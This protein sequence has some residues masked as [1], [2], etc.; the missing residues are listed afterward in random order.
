M[1]QFVYSYEFVGEIFKNLKEKHKSEKQQYQKCLKENYHIIQN[2][3]L[4]MKANEIKLNKEKQIQNDLKQ[5][6]MF[7]QTQIE[8]LEILVTKKN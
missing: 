6:I 8:K 2:L 4:K 7:D 5:Q 3:N 1:I